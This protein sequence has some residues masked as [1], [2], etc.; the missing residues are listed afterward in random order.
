MTLKGFLTEF[1]LNEVNNLDETELYEYK[2]AYEGEFYSDVA[3]KDKVL[4][5]SSG[6]E[7]CMKLIRGG[8]WVVHLYQVGTI[9]RYIIYTKNKNDLDSLRKSLLTID[10]LRKRA[11]IIKK[12]I[13]VLSSLKGKEIS[14]IEG[15]EEFKNFFKENGAWKYTYKTSKGE[16]YYKALFEKKCI[17]TVDVSF[18]YTRCTAEICLKGTNLSEPESFLTVEYI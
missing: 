9:P 6:C 4:S 2:P 15:L 1:G 10:D 17:L 16:E 12:N 8:T 11:D 18:D 13:E 3:I 5:D 14:S 7:K